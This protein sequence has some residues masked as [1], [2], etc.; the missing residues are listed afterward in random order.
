MLIEKYK[1]YKNNIIELDVEEVTHK[2]YTDKN[3]FEKSTQTVVV[4]HRS[5]YYSYPLNY[6]CVLVD[7]CNM[8]NLG[9]GKHRFYFKPDF[10]TCSMTF[11]GKTYNNIRVPSLT[12]VGFVDEK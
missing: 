1:D 6:N 12:L 9:K 2:T 3:G 4:V 10:K 7:E 11:S 5:G 8:L